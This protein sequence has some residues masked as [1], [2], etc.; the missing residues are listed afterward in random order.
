VGGV[1]IFKTK[2]STDLIKKFLYIAECNESKSREVTYLLSIQEKLFV[3]RI[4]RSRSFEGH[5]AHQTVPKKQIRANF[6]S[7]FC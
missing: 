3:T 7:I 1:N 2:L 5:G 6:N 4:C